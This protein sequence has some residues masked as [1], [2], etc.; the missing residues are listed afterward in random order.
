MRKSLIQPLLEKGKYALEA[1]TI[2]FYDNES[3]TFCIDSCIEQFGFDNLPIDNNIKRF[4]S[5]IKEKK[6]RIRKCVAVLFFTHTDS[7]IIAVS[8]QN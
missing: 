4:T 1:D 2:F 8:N 5:V 7:T 6:D 3:K